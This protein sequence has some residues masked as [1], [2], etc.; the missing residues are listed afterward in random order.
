MLDAAQTEQA[1]FGPNGAAE[2]MP[3]G[4]VVITSSTVAPAFA[5]ELGGRIEKC[6]LLHIDAP[7][8]GGSVKAAEG[9]L[10]I[11][12]SGPE[13]AF[14]RCEKVFAAIAAKVHRVG[15]RSGQGSQVKMINQL[16]AGVHIAAAAEAMALGIKAGADPQVLFDVISNSAGSPGCSRTGYRISSAATTAALGCQHL[17]QGSGDRAGCRAEIKV[18]AAAHRHGAPDVPQRRRGRAGFFEDD[19]AVVKIFPGIQLPK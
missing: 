15:E 14:E 11:M 13:V 16:L 2:A 9:Q 1:L 10:S 4:A 18:P 6:G 8:S 12:A 17:R 3:K 19:A 5:A 7:V